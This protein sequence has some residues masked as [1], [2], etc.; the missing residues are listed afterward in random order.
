MSKYT[1][2]EIEGDVISEEKKKIQFQQTGAG[3]HIWM[4][5]QHQNP[6]SSKESNDINILNNKI[7]QSQ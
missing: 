3:S 7:K 1:N 4:Y 2:I 5:E 6:T